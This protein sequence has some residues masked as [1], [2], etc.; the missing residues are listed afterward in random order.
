MDGALLL[1]A[2]H[3]ARASLARSAVQESWSVRTVEA[4]A[5]ERNAGAGEPARPHARR[6]RMTGAHPDQEEA[7][8]EIAEALG[9]ALGA[10]VSVRPTRDGGYR[11]ELSFTTP[12][13]ALELAR[14]LRPARGRI[15]RPSIS[16]YLLIYD[17]GAR[18]LS[19]AAS[20]GRSLP[21]AA[22]WPTS[23][24]RRIR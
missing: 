6:G 16:F 23:L 11:A 1:A 4:R 3:A 8:R 7:A 22:R 14:R 24:R 17:R 5:R 15:V 10:E 18:C 9:G 21:L 12:D 19:L 20:H 13:E 2:D